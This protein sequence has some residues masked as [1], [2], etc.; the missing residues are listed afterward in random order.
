MM[1]AVVHKF[2]GPQFGVFDEPVAADQSVVLD[3]LAAGINHLDVAKASGLFYDT[4]T[5]LPFVAGTDGI[6]RAEDGSRFYFDECVA[7]FGSLGERTLVHRDALLPVRDGVPDSTAAALGNAGM[8]AMIATAFRGEVRPGDRVVV[9]GA[10]GAVGQ[11]AVQIARILGALVV[12]AVGRD[13]AKLETLSI[14]GVTASI[15]IEPV[16]LLTDRLRSAAGGD[17][18]VIIDLICGPA[19]LAALAAVA[20]EARYVQVGAKAG[21]VLELPASLLR[22]RLLTVRGTAGVRESYST[23]A[24]A[25]EQLQNFYLEGALRV[26]LEEIPL[27]DIEYGWQRQRDGAGHKLIVIPAMPTAGAVS[28]QG[29]MQN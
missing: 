18:D 10:T 5:T 21:S 1:A 28:N 4:V 24:R 3:V 15:A 20:L 7:P 11:L 25:Y 2:T 9:L 22:S 29:A 17:V 8:A 27:S 12:V 23:R 13:L 16:D 19:A 6:G 26:G 14:L